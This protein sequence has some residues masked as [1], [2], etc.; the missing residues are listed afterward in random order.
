M[1]FGAFTTANFNLISAVDG[2]TGFTGTADQKGTKASPLDAKIDPYTT[3]GNGG[4][5]GTIRLL[6]GSPAIDKGKNL[7][8]GL[9]QRGQP[10]A[11]NL[12]DATYPNAVG[13]DGS[14][15]GAYEWQT[16]PNTRP[17]AYQKDLYNLVT[18]VA[19]SGKFAQGTDGDSDVLTFSLVSG[20]T[21]PAG[22]TLNANGTITGTASTPTVATVFFKVNDG[23]EDSDPAE[24]RLFV[25]EAPSLVVTTTDDTQSPYDGLTT[26]R[27]AIA[28]AQTDGVNTPVTFDATIFATAKTITLYQSV[29]AISNS[30]DLSGPAAGVTVNGRGQIG[31]FSISGGTVSLSMLTLANGSVP[32]LGGAVDITTGA[33]V[34]ITGCTLRDNTV[35]S[36]TAGGGAI[37]NRGGDLTLKNCTVAK[38]SSNGG[39]GGG[40]LQTS[41]TLTV[42]NCTIT[43]NAG[44]NGAGGGAYI[45]GGSATMG[46]C[47]V[48]G[49]T[50]GFDIVGVVASLGYNLIG[51]DTGTTFT[52]DTTGNQLNVSAG[53]DPDGLAYN[54]G[55]TQTI[56][57]LAGSFA[58]D[59]G[60]ALG[61]V[62]TDQRGQTRPFENAAVVNASGG[63]G[64]DIGAFEVHSAAEISVQQPA[65]TDLQDG[66]ASI[67]F[68]TQEVGSATDLDFTIK[69]KG[70][71]PLALNGT[72]RVAV[73]GAD[74]A[75][76]TVLAQPASTLAVGASATFTVRYVPG[77][78]GAKTTALA[79]SSDDADE[80]IY[81]I[82][83]TGGAQDGITVPPT[84]TSPASNGAIFPQATVIYTLPEAALGGSV[85]LSFNNGMTFDFVMESSAETLGEH[86]VHLDTAGAGMPLGA[87]TLTLSYRDTLGH[88]AASV[89]I[90]NVNLRPAS[91][92]TTTTLAQLAA[93]PGRGA[94]DLPMDAVL[95]SFNLPATDDDSDLAYVAKWSTPAKIKGTALF[96]NDKC[97]GLLGGS[98]P[99]L[100]GAT[101]ASFTDPVVDGG[102]VASIAGLKGTPKPP[103]TVVVS[104]TSGTSTLGIIAH[105]GDIAPDASGALLMGGATF[106]SF[107]AVAIHNGSIGIFA[108]LAGGSG[109]LKTTG[110]NDLGLW[111]KNGTDPLKLALREGQA[112]GSK[113]IKTLIAFMPGADSHGQGRGWLAEPYG[114]AV[115]GLVI[116][117]DKS[118]S[119]PASLAV[120]CKSFPRQPPPA[121]AAAPPSPARPS[122]ATAS[123]PRMTTPPSPSSAP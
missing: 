50:S 64:S 121:S 29:I 83:L 68:G 98:V 26:L 99:G 96:L 62:M 59:A 17:V 53:L 66:V 75:S 58:I 65:G 20:Y 122:P 6:P 31:I 74:A 1:F 81:N 39:L 22:L 14:D 76:F 36:F 38:N 110:T 119:S 85:L 44:G 78:T 52:G 8:G 92:V 72:P 123:R 37:A 101:F 67:A 33:V 49:N 46:N 100:T 71:L 55:T 11:A 5:T 43:Q 115:M 95:A 107:K 40:I 47:I 104:N 90:T 30:V 82:A 56:G 73:G 60:K 111:I 88:N 77:S 7:S 80:G 41:G 10:R 89:V 51:N 25:E 113:N 9:D 18:G 35:R 57:L 34:T 116:F 91:A 120:A 118:Q 54:G 13:G 70:T 32:S 19:L 4:T 105:A 84:L 3:A 87:Y 94:G 69:N 97:L 2:A 93:A 63:D 27:E 102:I 114:P 117:T 108:Q 79:I 45:Q 42:L 86:T 15:I 21:L 12:T 48:A 106:K 112:I 103:A 61:S 24:L 16:L 109:P 28:F 23:K